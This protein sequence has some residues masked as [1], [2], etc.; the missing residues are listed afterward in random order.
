MSIISYQL[1]QACQK[2]PELPM[3]TV[4]ST[5]APIVVVIFAVFFAAIFPFVIYSLLNKES[6][7]G[8]WTKKLA[9]LSGLGYMGIFLIGSALQI[10]K[11]I[12]DSLPVFNYSIYC[13]V[14][15]I[16]LFFKH[17]EVLAS[18]Y[19]KESAEINSWSTTQKN[20][21]AICILALIISVIYIFLNR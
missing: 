12:P 6:Y 21:V 2:N 19:P 10:L 5:I 13:L 15:I 20:I 16:P 1:N 4:M 18:I 9:Y 17:P 8:D 3:C 7:S 14:G 11:Y